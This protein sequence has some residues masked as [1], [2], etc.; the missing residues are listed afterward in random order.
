MMPSNLALK[1][2]SA[3]RTT[4]GDLATLVPALP[5]AQRELV[6]G[7]AGTWVGTGICDL[8]ASVASQQKQLDSLIDKVAVLLSSMHSEVLQDLRCAVATPEFEARLSEMRKVGEVLD[9]RLAEL[10]AEAAQVPEGVRML[11]VELQRVEEKMNGLDDRFRQD[12]EK[13]QNLVT[14]S[15]MSVHDRFTTEL[16]GVITELKKLE[17]RLG[18]AETDLGLLSDDDLEASLK[19]AIQQQAEVLRSE[20]PKFLAP[21]FDQTATRI[22]ALEAHLQREHND[23]L[24]ALQQ[25]AA[26]TGVQEGDRALQR[27]LAKRTKEDLRQQSEE[28]TALSRQMSEMKIWQSSAMEEAKLFRLEAKQ[29]EEDA[30]GSVLPALEERL[31]STTTRICQLE[32]Q[33]KADSTEKRLGALE[34]L[35]QGLEENMKSVEPLQRLAEDLRPKELEDRLL[36]ALEE[37]VDLVVQDLKRQ[38]ETQITD[39]V[40]R[41]E[42]QPQRLELRRDL[43]QRLLDANS[44]TQHLLADQR[45]DFDAR[46]AQVQRQGD[47]LRRELELKIE[48]RNSSTET[49]VEDLKHQMENLSAQQQ[50]VSKKQADDLRQL[51]AE[52]EIRM[53]KE[54]SA[55]Q[56]STLELRK[57]LERG[58][59]EAVNLCSEVL[60]EEQ[61]QLVR[62]FRQELERRLAQVPTPIL[63]EGLEEIQELREE[64]QELKEGME[65]EAPRPSGDASPN[66]DANRLLRSVEETVSEKVRRCDTAAE[67]CERLARRME[68]QL[69]PED[70]RTGSG[71]PGDQNAY[72]GM[73]LQREGP[74]SLYESK[75]RYSFDDTTGWLRT[76]GNKVG[77]FICRR[78]QPFPLALEALDVAPRR[79]LP[80]KVKIITSDV[81]AEMQK[82]E[83]QG[84]LFMVC[85]QLN[86][87]A[88]PSPETLVH[89]VEDYKHQHSSGAQGQLA[90]H[91]AA[92]QFLLDNAANVERV[93]GINALD[94]LLSRVEGF[95]V[96]NGYLKFLPANPAE[97]A[98]NLKNLEKELHNLRSVIMDDLSVKGLRPDRSLAGR[99]HRVG[100]FYASSVEGDGEYQMKVAELLLTAQY[101][102]ALRYAAES[103][104][105]RRR[106]IFLTPLSGVTGVPW[107]LLG[108]SMAKALQMLDEDAWSRLNISC[109]VGDAA[110]ASELR[111]LLQL[112]L[113]SS[114]P[115]ASKARELFRASDDSSDGDF[116][117]SPIEESSTESRIMVLMR[118]VDHQAS[119]LQSLR[120]KNEELSEAVDQYNLQQKVS[121]SLA[122]LE[123]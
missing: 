54:Q 107:E 99:D 42:T 59:Q 105:E 16:E 78:L 37:K 117:P 36:T 79:F 69:N 18:S 40:H 7:G 8:R 50:S 121:R 115:K 95:Q 12:F 10:R 90:A 77:R 63:V 85:S 64:L 82:V 55:V 86:G 33:V 23:L 13:V 68:W 46:L 103:S 101:Y 97:E 29:R 11:H 112:P 43:E 24:V 122:G 52:V 26:A 80:S 93:G 110:A 81:V 34:D 21:Y 25:A 15:L 30:F 60:R 66:R 39:L 28:L 1:S 65:A 116:R 67:M 98:E 44:K 49:S 102:G 22:N 53:V 58:A 70:T 123:S 51:S 6:A 2:S 76:A 104:T 57:D 31:A 45:E 38:L 17:T 111:G 48:K 109:L 72:E 19:E 4:V 119:E 71:V 56:R 61:A 108:R 88:Y 9:E 3:L 96:S 75:G 32:E 5:R 120:E 94:V 73:V 100:L 35:L 47:E 92:A 113:G 87:A 106:K 27:D 84:A 118:R 20:F 41:D 83:N 74:W 62:E 14:E 89:H 91:P 114:S